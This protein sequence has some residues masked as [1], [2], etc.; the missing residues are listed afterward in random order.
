MRQ[1]SEL[2]A[3]YRWLGLLPLMFFLAHAYYYWT[4]GGIPHLLWMCNVSNLVLAAGLLFGNGL[5]IRVA[6]IWLIPGVPIWV[7]F[8]VMRGGWLWTSLFNHV[9]GLAIALIALRRV[10]A[11]RRT[12]IHAVTWYFTMQLIS[13][14]T[15]P[16]ELNVNI[17]HKVYE[18]FET[19]FSEYWQYW[20]ATTSLV[21]VGAWL[22]GAFLFKIFPPAEE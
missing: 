18:G 12:W 2:T 1:D 7:W 20:L 13:R 14:L 4:H 10:R 17:S 15:T 6:V 16:A 22:L 3:E 8:V 5:L 9:G 21:V 11:G 19:W